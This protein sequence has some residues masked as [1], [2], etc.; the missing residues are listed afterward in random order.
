MSAWLMK[1]LS[2]QSKSVICGLYLSKFDLGGLHTL[3]L[4]S[5]SEAFNVIGF[6]LGVPPASIKNYR[7][8]FDPLF[9]NPRKGWHKRKT[10][11]YCKAIYDEFNSLQIGEFS[12]LLKQIIYKDHDLDLLME[13]VAVSANEDTSFAKRLITGQAAEHYFTQ[14]Y[15]EI[16]IFREFEL[17]DKTKY[18]CGFDFRLVARDQFYAIEVKGMNDKSGK[19]TMTHK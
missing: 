2:L 12:K 11:E 14:K 9:P 3:D 1:K 15:R 18:G 16:E 8:E 13:E 17:E 19:I 6:S 5:F 10:R 4:E 7:D